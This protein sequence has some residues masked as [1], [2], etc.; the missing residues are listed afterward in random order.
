VDN[1]PLTL[2]DG[3]VLATVALSALVGLTR[4]AVAEILGLANWIGAAVLA[5]LAWPQARSLVQDAT[6][7]GMIA[8]LVAVGGVFLVALVVLKLVTGMV[9]RAVAAS[10]LGPFDKLLGLLFGAARGAILV[11]AGYFLASQFVEPELQPPWVREALLIQPVRDGAARL[12]ELIPIPD[13]TGEPPGGQPWAA[14]QGRAP[15][16]PPAP[17]R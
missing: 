15:V 6:G 17:E 14:A 3:I 9:T 11:C 5:Y 12:A 10:A 8:D 13:E 16:A 7:D 4:G 1:L 2:F